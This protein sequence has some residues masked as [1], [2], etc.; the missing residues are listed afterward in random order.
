[1]FN[2]NKSNIEFVEEFE[3]AMRAW[4]DENIFEALWSRS[5]E[6]VFEF[7]EVMALLSRHYFRSQRK[8]NN[9]FSFIAN[10]SLSG[11]RHP[12][13]ALEC[14][15]KKL[16][17]LASF[18]LLY[19][20]EVYIHNPFEETMLKG[21]DKFSEVDR[22]ELGIGIKNFFH[23]KPL[24]EKGIIKYAQNL[25]SLC[26]HH[27]EVFADPILKKIDQNQKSLYRAIHKY[28]LERCVASFDSSEGGEVF[29]E[30][31]GPG[32]FIDHE[33]IFFHSPWNKSEVC[34]H[35]KFLKGKQLPYRLSR[36]ELVNEEILSLVINPILSDLSDQEWH[37]AFHGTSYL[38]D[39]PTQIKLASR[40]NDSTLSVNSSAFEVGMK[41][42]L[43]V[44][45]SQSMKSILDLREREEEAF[46]V[47]RDKVSSMMHETNTSD[48][49]EIS[50]VFRDQ[51]LPEI[52]II[53]KKIKDWKFSTRESLREKIIFGAGAVS[54][55]LYAGILPP[56]IG[57]FVAA[58]GG[59]SAVMGALMDFNKTLKRNHIARS[60]DFYFLWQANQ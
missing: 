21:I 6:E 13:S 41:H 9:K 35:V 49:A 12:C 23:L 48:E 4:A 5:V 15:N 10:S 43:P 53:D 3:N 60:N 1:M 55:G 50:K 37:S 2:S 40:V 34:K 38:C 52:N 51:V 47:Y 32:D 59:G 11:G 42:Y 36:D 56:D 30:I 44:V 45:Y 28:L 46:A 14:R 31:A 20:D 7:A 57:Q 22:Q 19:A 58:A 18:A 54:I 39:N 26:Q 27:K 16:V 17:Q 29:L 25:S 8:N 33:K 24:F